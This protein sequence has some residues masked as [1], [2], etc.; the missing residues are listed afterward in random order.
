MSSIGGG[1]S[2]EG[3]LLKESNAKQM[4]ELRQQYLEQLH[5]KFEMEGVVE[6]E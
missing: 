3:M 2:C 5:E 1:L 6:V 4:L